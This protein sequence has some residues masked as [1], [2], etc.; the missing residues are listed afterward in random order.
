[1]SASPE[2]FALL[3]LADTSLTVGDSTET[4]YLALE[5]VTITHPGSTSPQDRDV[6][7]VLRVNF[8]ETPLDPERVVQRVDSPGYRRY[9]F[10]GTP[11][12][13]SELTLSFKLPVPEGSNPAYLEDL[14]TFENIIGQYHT[15]LRAAVQET[16]TSPTP[17]SLG[18]VTI[19][20]TTQ[21]E[22]DLRGHLVM[23][24]EKSGEVV[25][26]VED[27]FRIMEDPS[28]HIRGHENDPVIIEVSGESGAASDA[29]ALEA[30]ARIV[31]P[32]QQNW[33]TSTATVVR[34]VLF[35]TPL[36]Y[37]F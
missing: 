15:E 33:I 13:P 10:T 32:D 2:A 21:N 34:H 7:L 25:G 9:I 6:Y 31:P 24:D 20:G 30:F 14:D 12:D 8:T 4:G 16:P 18:N 1:M 3:V 5:C 27:S 22:K 19:G 28:M 37:T 26:Q 29:R 36:F 35:H 23:V 17:K 11:A